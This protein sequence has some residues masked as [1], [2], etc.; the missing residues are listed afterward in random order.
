M[1]VMKPAHCGHK[2]GQNH[3]TSPILGPF[4]RRLLS[5]HVIFK[6]T[7]CSVWAI[8]AENWKQMLVFGKTVINRGHVLV[9]NSKWPSMWATKMG[10]C[11]QGTAI[12]T[13]VV[14]RFGEFVVTEVTKR[15]VI[16]RNCSICTP[17]LAR[18]CHALAVEKSGVCVCRGVC[19]CV[20]CHHLRS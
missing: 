15:Q 7:N 17:L 20:A 13:W 10:S 1:T 18:A 8:I 9:G 12:E 5:E 19:G 14:S 3:I 2:A 16:S 6:Q 4:L 11:G